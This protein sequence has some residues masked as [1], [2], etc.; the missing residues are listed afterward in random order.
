LKY[1]FI[2]FYVYYIK[3]FNIYVQ[4]YFK[5]VSFLITEVNFFNINVTMSKKTSSPIY[6]IYDSH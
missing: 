1:I 4:Y 6:L 2:K 5:I 3:L